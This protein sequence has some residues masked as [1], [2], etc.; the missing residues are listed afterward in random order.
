MSRRVRAACA[1]VLIAAAG[2]RGEEGSEKGS[3]AGRAKP[4]GQT[5]KNAP[6]ASPRSADVYGT[7][8]A[9]LLI[10]TT[11]A[12]ALFG[13]G[14]DDTLQGGEGNDTLEGGSG[15]DLIEGGD[16]ADVIYGDGGPGAAALEASRFLVQASFGGSRAEIEA[17]AQRGAEEWFRDQLALPRRSVLTRLEG[18][19]SQQTGDLTG[20][21][22]ERAVFADDQLRQR[23]AYALSQITV[24]SM[25][26]TELRTATTTFAVYMDHLEAQAF[27]NYEDLIRALTFDPAMGLWLSHIANRA[28]DPE[29]GNAPDE[30]YAREMMQLFTLGTAPLDAGGRPMPGETFTNADVE[31]LAAVMTGLTWADHPYGFVSWLPTDRSLRT[32]P[33]EIYAD[34]HETGGKTVLGRTISGPDAAASIDDAL[35]I[36]LSHP[37]VPVFVAQRLI[38]RLVSSN[39]SPAYVARVAAA[40]DTGRFVLPESR[41]SVGEGR[42]G[43]MTATIAAILFDEEA[44]VPGEEASSGKLREPVLRL[45]QLLRAYRLDREEG[46]EAPNG[47]LSELGWPNRV[48]QAPL[49]APSVFNFYQADH[50][51]PGTETGAM[52]LYGPELQ[53]MASASSA[54]FAGLMVDYTRQG[55]LGAFMDWDYDTLLALADEPAALA[56]EL[57]VVLTRGRLSSEVRARLVAALGAIP[58]QQGREA[59]D[60]LLRVRVALALVT[61]S[62]EYAVQR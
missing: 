31:G 17:L 28:A 25:D 27:G 49:R 54:G 23:I 13:R 55:G 36:V 2:C 20:I 4:N 60:R 24:V 52:G 53:I 40:Y 56:D 3:E 43:D 7:S 44:R 8:D 42:R 46:P 33:M 47:P 26:Q 1:V 29:L 62:P 38:Q 51:A 45:A 30:N 58:V 37:N 5:T 16:G 39:P 57:D 18:L 12:D 22:W 61:T 34:F 41:R 19:A 50:V 6:S 10:G 35:D 9:D 21:W 32:R 59:D 15:D 14:G 48:G 11:D